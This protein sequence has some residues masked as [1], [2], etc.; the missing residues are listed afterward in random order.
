MPL[1]SLLRM[2]CFFSPKM[3][4]LLRH[5]Y[6]K[7]IQK[8]KTQISGEKKQK[9]NKIHSLKDRQGHTKHVCKISGSNSQKTAW[10]LASEEILGFML[11]PACTRLPRWDLFDL[12]DLHMFA[13]PDLYNVH[14][15][16]MFH[17]VGSAWS[18]HVSCGD[19]CTSNWW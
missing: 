4:R 1:P 16:H 18:S 10:T 8:P 2:V 13:M 11:E 14:G 9:K 3:W 6:P 15:L 12:H 7:K 5:K 19:I 17:Q